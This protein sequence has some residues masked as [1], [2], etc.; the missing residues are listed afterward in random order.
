M[1][2]GLTRLFYQLK[3]NNLL[4]SNGD[5]ISKVVILPMGDTIEQCIKLGNKLRENNINNTI[6]FENT[7]FKNKILYAT[8]SNAKYAVIVG[9]DEVANGCFTLKNLSEFKQEQ[10]TFDEIVKILKD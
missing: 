6:L 2:I 10:K 3:Q 7:K 9:E 5:S 1:S 8:K 4:Q